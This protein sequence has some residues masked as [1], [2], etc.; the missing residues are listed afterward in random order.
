VLFAVAELLV[1]IIITF[2]Y[3]ASAVSPLT[4]TVTVPRAAFYTSCFRP[5]I[6]FHFR[7]TGTMQLKPHADMIIRY[8]LMTV[9]AMGLALQDEVKPAFRSRI[10]QK[11]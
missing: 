8:Y 10:M 5:P 4:V 6:Q 9:F 3:F 2:H 7:I 11:T 1:I